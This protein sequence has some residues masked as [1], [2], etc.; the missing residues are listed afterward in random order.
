MHK[1][2]VTLRKTRK[3]AQ[4]R[5]ITNRHEPL[6]LAPCE[7]DA[8]YSRK[9]TWVVSLRVDSWR[10]ISRSS[11][12]TESKRCSNTQSEISGNLCRLR[13][14]SKVSIRAAILLRDQPMVVNGE[15]TS[16]PD[17]RI[18]LE[19]PPL[20]RKEKAPEFNILS[21]NCRRLERFADR[22][23]I[24]RIPFGKIQSQRGPFPTRS[25]PLRGLGSGL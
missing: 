12:H 4:T 14:R 15:D 9:Y 5:C 3:F 23:R 20:I 2:E 17:V 7:I 25:S 13:E 21:S 11:Y 8:W 6:S 1:N 22:C 19:L 10:L 18:R 16:T 24:L